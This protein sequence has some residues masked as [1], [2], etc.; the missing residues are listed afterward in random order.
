[1][2][3]EEKKKLQYLLDRYRRGKLNQREKTTVS[4]WLARLDLAGNQQGKASPERQQQRSWAALEPELYPRRSSPHPVTMRWPAMIAASIIVLITVGIWLYEREPSDRAPLTWKTIATK[5]GETKK[6]VLPDGSSVTLNSASRFSVPASFGKHSRVVKLEGQGF[7]EVAHDA[8]KPFTVETNDLRVR[9]LGTSFDVK[10]YRGDAD[11]RIG[12][13]SGSVGVSWNA[14]GSDTSAV[15]RT[16]DQLQ[17]RTDDGQTTISSIDT[18]EASAWRQ[19]RLR[20]RNEPLSVI[21]RDLE[22][23]FGIRVVF[24]NP[25]LADQKFSLDVRS[26]QLP[27][28]IEALRISGGIHHEFQGQTLILW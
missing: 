1:M 23:Q 2:E 27:Q 21:A 24:N 10:D 26:P 3:Q 4:S 17:Y 19:D 6:I 25:T 9:V 7:F 20:Y 5:A 22:R 28:L 12:V 18:V 15:L 11:A 16:G 13:T 8:S 14:S